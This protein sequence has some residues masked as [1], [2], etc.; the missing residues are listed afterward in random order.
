LS[1]LHGQG[2]NFI[3]ANTYP[4]HHASASVAAQ[5]GLTATA[6]EVDG[7]RVWQTVADWH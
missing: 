1:W 7:E 3:T 4:D 6:E 2:A 5:A